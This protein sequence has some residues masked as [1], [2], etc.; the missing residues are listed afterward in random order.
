ME[1]SNRRSASLR[2]N[3][4]MPKSCALPLSSAVRVGWTTDQ[5]Q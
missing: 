1:T 4:M 5:V 2:V 3:G